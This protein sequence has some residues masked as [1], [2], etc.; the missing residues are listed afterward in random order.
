MKTRTVHMPDEADIGSGEKSPGQH[1]TEKLIE[2][3]SGSSQQ[4]ADA[5]SSRDTEMSRTQRTAAP[6]DEK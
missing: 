3:V 4:P 6:P 1:D 5:S 2:Q